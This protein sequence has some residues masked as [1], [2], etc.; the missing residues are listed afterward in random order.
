MLVW[1]TLLVTHENLLP[2]KNTHVRAQRSI[3]LTTPT[4]TTITIRAKLVP[5]AVGLA[6]ADG[7]GVNSDETAVTVGVSKYRTVY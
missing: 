1:H 5:S 7:G 2:Q 6:T 3:R 4:N